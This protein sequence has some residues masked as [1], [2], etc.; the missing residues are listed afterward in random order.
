MKIYFDLETTGTDISSDRIIQFAAIQQDGTEYNMY[1]NPGRPIP[2]E[3]T[4]IHHIT[5]EMVATAPMF[6]EH[7][8]TIYDLIMSADAV[9]GFNIVRFDLPMLAEELARCGYNLPTTIKIIDAQVIFHTMEQRTLK[10]A[11]AFYCNR[12]LDD[13]HN[14]LFDT[15]ATIDVLD[16]QLKRYT[17]LSNNIDELHKL[18]T[19][20]SEIVDWAGK[21]GKDADG[22][23]IL[24]FGKH[25]GQKAKH[26]I[27]Y[28]DWML[29]GNFPQSTLE[30]CRDIIEDS[31]YFTEGDNE[32]P[33]D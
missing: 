9:C 14:A 16:A 21:F 11:L 20:G 15:K 8:H 1:F 27:D 6:A 12:D 7:A 2:K 30:V 5:D 13:A 25:R 32:H 10:A 24:M 29:N 3:S 4:E 18:S 19:R 31:L 22:D 17:E 26:H 33:F 28:L 23:I